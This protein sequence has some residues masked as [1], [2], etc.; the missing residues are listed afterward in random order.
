MRKGIL[1][2][3]VTAAILGAFSVMAAPLA[4]PG[5]ARPVDSGIDLTPQVAPVFASGEP[6]EIHSWMTDNGALVEPTWRAG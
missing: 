4:A 3:G 1:A 2:V 6:V 5:V